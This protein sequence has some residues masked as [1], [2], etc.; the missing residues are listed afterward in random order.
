[1]CLI[2]SSSSAW[3]MTSA[4]CSAQACIT[5]KAA[6]LSIRTPACPVVRSV[7]K[8]FIV[9]VPSAIAPPM[10]ATV[11]SEGVPVSTGWKAKSA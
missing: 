8:S 4:P 2:R 11:A 6:P 10:L 9:D 3:T 1:M 7:V 5:S